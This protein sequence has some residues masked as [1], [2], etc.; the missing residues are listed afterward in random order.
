MSNKQKR[1]WLDDMPD[2]DNFEFKW[3]ACD[4]NGIWYEYEYKPRRGRQAFRV[5]GGNFQA[6]DPEEM[7]ELKGDQWKKSRISIAKLKR[8]QEKALIDSHLKERTTGRG[9]CEVWDVVKPKSSTDTA[10]VTG[11][12]EDC[13]LSR[14]YNAYKLTGIKTEVYAVYFEGNINGI[15]LM[16]TWTHGSYKIHF[17]LDGN[18]I[19]HISQSEF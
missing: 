7:P 10:L 14:F 12:H 19:L 2:A 11:S 9:D 8:H 16:T 18:F 3:L 5:I 4:K 15:Q 6:I 17:S 1:P 13:D